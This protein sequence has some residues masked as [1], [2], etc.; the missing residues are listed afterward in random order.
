[1]IELLIVVVVIAILTMVALPS[2]ADYVRRG[3]L[4]GAFENL[5][6]YRA[7]LEQFYQD[8]GNYGVN[9]C[10]VSAPSA[11]PNFQFSCALTNSGQ[12]FTATATG[13]G[14]M[15]GYTYTTDDAGNATTTQFKGATLT[16]AKACWWQRSGDC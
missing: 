15:A 9:S 11:S 7:Q 1:M 5:G 2:Y 12:G 3:Q 4:A 13:I 8:S 6:I 10:G 16:P 14:M